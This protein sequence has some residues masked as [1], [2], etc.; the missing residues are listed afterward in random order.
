[1]QET[2]VWSLGWEDPLEK[3]KTTHSSVLAWRIPWSLESM[4]LQWVRQDWETF[5]HSLTHSQLHPLCFCNPLSPPP[6]VDSSFKAKYSTGLNFLAN[7]AFSYPYISACKIPWVNVL[8]SY[9]G[10]SSRTQFLKHASIYGQML[11]DMVEIWFLSYLSACLYFPVWWEPH[12]VFMFVLRA[13]R[14]TH[15]G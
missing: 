10:S 8:P 14:F 5:T 9:L 3:R 11:L 12:N 13:S 7:N 1:M 4:G 2:W 6:Y 15:R